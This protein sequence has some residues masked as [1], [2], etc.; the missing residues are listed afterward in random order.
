MFMPQEGFI[1]YKKSFSN[2]R[3]LNWIALMIH[4]KV[5]EIRKGYQD[6]T[7]LET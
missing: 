7:E 4:P 3:F 6:Y 2:T 5:I 1:Q